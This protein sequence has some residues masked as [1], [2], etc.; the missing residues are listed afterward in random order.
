M[1][2]RKELSGLEV[3]NTLTLDGES[4]YTTAD[5]ALSDI[6]RRSGGN[7]FTGTQSFNNDISLEKAGSPSLLVGTTENSGE[8]A[9]ITFRGARTSL[10]ATIAQIDFVNNLSGAVTTAA[11][12]LIGG[13]GDVDLAVGQ[14]L[15]AGATVWH[16][17][18]DG[19]GSG[20]DADLLD[21]N[22][23]SAFAFLTGAT[24]TGT[25]QAPTLRVGANDVW[26]AG[27][28]GSGSGLNA[29]LLDG[30]HGSAFAKLSGATFTGG[31]TA[32]G[33]TGP[34]GG[35]TGVVKPGDNATLKSLTITDADNAFSWENG[36]HWINGNDG[37]GNAQIR[38]GNNHGALN[39]GGQDEVFT[40]AGTAYYIGGNVDSGAGTLQLKVATNGGAGIG[41]AV[42]WGPTLT[43]GPT[44][45]LW[46]NNEVVHMGNLGSLDA[47]AGD[48]VVQQDGG[49]V[50][51]VI[52]WD[53]SALDLMLGTKGTAGTGKVSARAPLE[54]S[55]G[56]GVGGASPDTS[57]A[58]AFYGTNLLLNSGSSINM[59]FNKNA[60]GNDASL[61]FQS[62]FTTNALVGLLGNNDLTFKVGT[63]FTTAMVLS[64]ADGTVSFPEGIKQDAL[65]AYKTTSQTLTASYA[66]LT[67]WTGTHVAASG[68]LSWS[69]ANGD[70]YVGKAGRFMV[71][72]SVSTEISTGSARTD[73]LAVLQQW[74]GTAWSDV[75]GT[76]HRMYN[77]ISGRGGSC[78]AWQGVLDLGASD[79]LRV[80]AR[81]ETGTDTVIVD[82]A[83]LSVVRL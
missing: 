54:A 29:D 18:N 9:N 38:F 42:A 4:V 52:W 46:N 48:F 19:A 49:G 21:G 20:L 60:A 10:S 67:S 27:N 66:T 7:S 44:D 34:G 78:A 39:A 37:G 28:D 17:N 6:A 25:V 75:A 57:N 63:G 53:Y 45:L 43:I 72:Y 22:H 3:L 56:L 5:F 62:G 79:G 41:E 1:G 33:F 16:G 76:E 12:W 31:V 73:S 55:E 26:H 2:A 82:S 36:A 8:Q 51:N 23:A 59:K 15:V 35:L 14:L 77:R 30:D 74:N 13:D 70:A 83:S 81:I 47:G 50:T 24:F 32:T 65:T 58:F 64:N 71:S 68:N 80:A 40:H 61:T 69:A 11:Q